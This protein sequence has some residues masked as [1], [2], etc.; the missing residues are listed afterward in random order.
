MASRPLHPAFWE[1]RL[2]NWD[3][4]CAFLQVSGGVVRRCIAAAQ[5]PRDFELPEEDSP[6]A[7]DGAGR[8]PHRE[9]LSWRPFPLF[10]EG[11]FWAFRLPGGGSPKLS[12]LGDLADR[13]PFP[14]FVLNVKG[15]LKLAND[16]FRRLAGAPA[17]GKPAVSTRWEGLPEG[18]R[19]G[20]AAEI[21]LEDAF[22]FRFSG[23]ERTVFVPAYT[24]SGRPPV[25][26][27][28]GMPDC[29]PGLDEHFQPPDALPY[30]KIYE[31]LPEGLIVLDAEGLIQSANSIVCERSG[32]SLEDMA[33]KPILQFFPEEQHATLKT[34]IQNCLKTGRVIRTEVLYPHSVSGD[35]I[36]VFLTVT[37]MPGEE[38]PRLLLLLEDRTRW[39]LL[40]S[41]SH[42]AEKRYEKLFQSAPDLIFT[43]LLDGTVLLFNKRCEELLGWSPALVKG[44]QI[45]QD[46]PNLPL[47][48]FTEW[49]RRVERAEASV[50]PVPLR[51]QCRLKDVAGVLRTFQVQVVPYQDDLGRLIGITIHLHDETANRLLQER[52]AESRER[53]RSLV[54]IP[55]TSY[56]SSH[57]RSKCC[58]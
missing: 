19:Q 49:L 54:K 40:E 24:P 55:P 1:E 47:S 42:A 15:R 32:V 35:T 28:G 16:H 56:F 57:R 34:A 13:L 12:A 3:A 30:R 51:S 11:W 9:Q 31:D 18:L 17:G 26:V 43:C 2:T 48:L 7:P 4:P 46:V 45:G 37:R 14:A 53:F 22:G 33:G 10:G 44:G 38:G 36:R 5:W 50:E 21:H 23:P 39:R 27:L 6:F 25:L 29:V 41:P 58:T 20:N 8:N 52:L